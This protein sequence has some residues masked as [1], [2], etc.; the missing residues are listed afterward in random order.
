MSD[1][2]EPERVAPSG[3]TLRVPT[4]DSEWASLGAQVAESL[5]AL[6]LRPGQAFDIARTPGG[7]R[8]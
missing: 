4:R 5:I 6:E 1:H 8:A 2:P 7:I 3:V